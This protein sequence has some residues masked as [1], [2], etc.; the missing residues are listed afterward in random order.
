MSDGGS[1]NLRRGADALA[2]FSDGLKNALTT[3]EQSPANPSELGH[4]GLDRQS[5]GGTKI[6][7]PEADYLHE[8]YSDV[9]GVLMDMSATLRLHIEALQ[10]A[11]HS[12]DA[13]YDG[14]EEEVRRR[15][16]EIKAKLDDEYQKTHPK[17]QQQPRKDTRQHTDDKSAGVSSQ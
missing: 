8:K 6:P 1:A 4:H 11:A 15:F 9:H 13:T 7:F 10:C 12:A 2:K 14:T 5:F 16:W 17:E 3:F